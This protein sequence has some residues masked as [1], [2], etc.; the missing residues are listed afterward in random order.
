MARAPVPRPE[1][2]PPADPDRL[3]SIDGDP[4][5][6]VQLAEWFASRRRPAPRRDAAP[7]GERG[8]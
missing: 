1:F 7:A 8:R 5:T 2:L 4:E 3:P 6:V